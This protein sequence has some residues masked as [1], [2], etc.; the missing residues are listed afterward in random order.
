MSWN[1]NRNREIPA[2]EKGK[3]EE[4]LLRKSLFAVCQMRLGL[5]EYDE[6][7][8]EYENE[9]VV[10]VAQRLGR[11]PVESRAG[12]FPVIITVADRGSKR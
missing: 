7:W 12:A 1:T 6:T 9:V 10:L 4:D 2:A 11:G 5:S 8:L 3:G